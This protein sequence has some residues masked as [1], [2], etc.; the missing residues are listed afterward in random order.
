M[1]KRD[2][3]ALRFGHFRIPNGD[4]SLSPGLRGT[5][6]PGLKSVADATPQGLHQAQTVFSSQAIPCFSRKEQRP[7]R[8]RDLVA[9]RH[10]LRSWPRNREATPLGLSC[11]TRDPEVLVPRNP[12]LG[13][14]A[15]SGQARQVKVGKS[16]KGEKM[17]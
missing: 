10:A 14:S 6:T 3:A 5:S 13:D 2:L 16:A 9:T 4:L 7:W 12:R 8:S 1:L 15:P 11:E 17:P